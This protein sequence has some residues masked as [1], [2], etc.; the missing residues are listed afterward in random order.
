MG[1]MSP[2]YAQLVKAIDR[3]Y[4][5]GYSLPSDQLAPCRHRQHLDDPLTAHGDQPVNHVD[6]HAHVVGDH[7]HHLADLGPEVAT[8][9]VEETVL[10][11]EGGNLDLRVLQDEAEAVVERA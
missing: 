8:G 9:Q 6:H 7:L 2:R 11:G 10:L 1:S 5:H 3:G 4:A